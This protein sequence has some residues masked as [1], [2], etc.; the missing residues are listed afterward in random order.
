M[1]KQ[2]IVECLFFQSGE[3]LHKV[4]GVLSWL[5]IGLLV[6]AVID[7]V[8]SWVTLSPAFLLQEG[9]R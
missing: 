2:F 1:L 8:G 3:K 5:S 6:Y 9:E 7:L 4:F